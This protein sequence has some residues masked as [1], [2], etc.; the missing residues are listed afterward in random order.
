MNTTPGGEAMPIRQNAGSSPTS[1]VRDE[2][3]EL[4]KMCHEMEGLFLRQLLEA[5][6]A[7]AQGEGLFGT[8]QGEEI[9]TSMLDDRLASEAAQKMNRGIGEALYRQMVERLDAQEG[10]CRTSTPQAP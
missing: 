6:R 8:S 1:A 3:A 5:M 10:T 4:R 2:R 7:T 9:F